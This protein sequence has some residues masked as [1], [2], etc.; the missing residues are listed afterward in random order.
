MCTKGGK[1]VRDTKALCEAVTAANG[2]KCVWSGSQITLH[3][4]SAQGSIPTP[5]CCRNNRFG[6][7]LVAYGTL[8]STGK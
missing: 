5:E 7:R 3:G 2:A 1:G 6:W 4:R 8:L